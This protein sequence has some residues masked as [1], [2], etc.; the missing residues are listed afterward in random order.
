[1]E[2]KKRNVQFIS[3][4]KEVSKEISDKEIQ[5]YDLNLET[6]EEKD[7]DCFIKEV[8]YNNKTR[9]FLL[10]SKNVLVDPFADNT[11]GRKRSSFMFKPVSDFCAK[12]YKMYLMTKNQLYFNIARRNLND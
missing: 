7:N 6:C 11:F 1:M 3:D 4:A 10:F 9:S 8:S 2:N 12:N 5:F